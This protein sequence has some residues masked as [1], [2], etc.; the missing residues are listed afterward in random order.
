MT[1]GKPALLALGAIV[2]IASAAATIALDQAGIVSI[3]PGMAPSRP[4]FTASIIAPIP[5]SPVAAV[6]PPDAADRF[7][8]VSLDSA[9]LQLP[10]PAQV[11][12]RE[13]SIT[14]LNVEIV[15]PW[16]AEARPEPKAPEQTALVAPPQ[17]SA[18]TTQTVP[19]Q[20]PRARTVTRDPHLTRRLAQISPGATVR[21]AQKFATAKA[22]WPPADIALVAIKD[23]KL[24]E[25]H[26]RSE[27]GAWKFV[28]RYPVTAASG[29]GGPKLRQGD[30]Q[31]PEG[32]YRISFLN[33]HSRYHVSL[34][35]NYPNAFD[36]QM[37]AADGRHDLGGDIMIHGKAASIGCL[38]VG[39]EAAEELFVL[40][41]N[42]GLP[43]VALVIAPSDFRRRGVP[44]IE[45]GQ[46]K[47]LPQL[48]TEVAS[49]MSEFKPPPRS[50]M[51][52]FFGN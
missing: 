26:A 23:E 41:A 16:T 19:R 9:S 35:V 12:A 31:V 21:L 37:A 4:E 1:L 3:G 13:P 10:L 29:I 40:A 22:A 48:Y 11:P 8:Y 2:S 14:T 28:H 33:P 6:R 46:P 7:T 52:S 27:G 25:L 45:A 49:A 43:N 32:V 36:R 17:I 30:K 39:D 47:W 15:R 34:R 42:V 18:W 50:N 51:L 24:I 38:A 20:I 44:T 5:P